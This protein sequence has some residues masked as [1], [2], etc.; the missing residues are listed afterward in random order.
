VGEDRFATFA[1]IPVTLR[2]TNRT[3]TNAAMRIKAREVPAH[4]AEKL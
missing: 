2:V 4:H 3:L 1:Y